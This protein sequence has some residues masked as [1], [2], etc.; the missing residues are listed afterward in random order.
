[1]SSPDR[2]RRQVVIPPAELIARDQAIYSELLVIFHRAAIELTQ[3]A[4]MALQRGAMGSAAYRNRQLTAVRNV[5]SAMTDEAVPEMA[6]VVVRSYEVGA[7]DMVAE[8]EAGGIGFSITGGFGGST[9][10]EAA[11]ILVENA[12]ARVNTLA[13]NVGRQVEDVFRRAGL[14]QVAM[15]VVKGAGRRAVS[16]ELAA[17][18]RGRGVRAFTDS[19]GRR[20]GLERYAEMVA[21]TTTREAQT[22]GRINRLL[23]NGLDLVTV[24]KHEHPADVCD[25]WEG[26]TFSLTGKTEGY[27]VLDRYPPFHPNCVH[28]L[29]PA[30]S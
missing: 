20:W 11:R 23:E 25:E 28:V 17:D 6:R 12:T 19:A 8:G 1:M 30:R 26:R 7:A 27:P 21:R 22:Q 13:V 24:S 5:L 9:H 16:S 18:L 14:D 15:G 10:L 2:T 3:E 4:T 29:T